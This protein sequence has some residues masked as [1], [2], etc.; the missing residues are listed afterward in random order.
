MKI[1][2]AHTALQPGKEDEGCLLYQM[3]AGDH[4]Q[5]LSFLLCKKG[6]EKHLS[7]RVTV[8]IR[9]GA[10]ARALRT[11]MGT[12]TPRL[13]LLC[14]QYYLTVLEVGIGGNRKVMRENRT[15]E[16]GES[17]GSQP[18]LNV[19]SYATKSLQ[20]KRTN[21][22]TD[23]FCSCWTLGRTSQAGA[24]QTLFCHPSLGAGGDGGGVHFSPEKEIFITPQFYFCKGKAF[25]KPLSDVKPF[26]TKS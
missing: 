12:E 26:S 21:I 3:R 18:V 10:C 13:L 2:T 5:S 14:W 4:R 1:H 20:N 16:R 19:G 25:K 17:L 9:V 22:H 6:R 7:F 24:L 8:R 15:S 23:S 11:V